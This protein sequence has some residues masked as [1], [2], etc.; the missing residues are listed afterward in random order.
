VA[1]R[2]DLL[3]GV[4]VRRAVVPLDGSQDAPRRV[5]WSRGF[6]SVLGGVE[7]RWF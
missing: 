2:L 5:A 3:G 4:S 6:A 1:L 7:A